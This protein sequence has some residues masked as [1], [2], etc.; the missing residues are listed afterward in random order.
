MFCCAG[1]PFFPVHMWKTTLAQCLIQLLP[2][3]HVGGAKGSHKPS[4]FR[5]WS[6]FCASLPHTV[7]GDAGWDLKTSHGEAVRTPKTGNAAEQGF[8]LHTS[9]LVVTCC[10]S[11]H[12]CLPSLEAL[13][14]VVTSQSCLLVYRCLWFRRPMVDGEGQEGICGVASSWLCFRLGEWELK[15]ARCDCIPSQS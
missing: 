11:A 9:E 12:C 7:F 4:C 3:T 10:P 5:R 15:G 1:A 14:W 2:G 13:C 8:A 6:P